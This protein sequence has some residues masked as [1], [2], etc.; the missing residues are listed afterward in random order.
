MHVQRQFGVQVVKGTETDILT[1]VSYLWQ[2]TDNNP[3]Y[4]LNIDPG[5][6]TQGTV[7]IAAS[8]SYAIQLPDAYDSAER[9]FVFLKTDKTIKAV[10]VSPVDPTST[11]LIYAGAGDGQEGVFTTCGRV[12]SI[13]L[14][15]PQ[16][17]TAT[18]EYFL[19]QLPPIAYAAAFRD[20]NIATGIE[21][22]APP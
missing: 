10:T 6:F 8:G 9:L 4:V 5:Q 7:E 22:G 14:S 16:T 13:T 11:V 20:G 2:L 3:R 15:N 12:T 18:V 21:T 1:N 17:A 19:F